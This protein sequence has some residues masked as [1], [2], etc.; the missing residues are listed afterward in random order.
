MRQRQ[1]DGMETSQFLFLLESYMKYLCSTELTVIFVP[2]LEQYCIE[3]VLNFV[4]IL[5][6]ICVDL[7]SIWSR[8]HVDFVFI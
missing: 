7:K 2:I 8:F 5:P 3:F 6:E 1:V 4:L